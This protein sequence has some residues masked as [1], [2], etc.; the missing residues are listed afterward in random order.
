MESNKIIS[1]HHGDL[2]FS[3]KTCGWKENPDG[4]LVLCLH[5]FPDN[6]S[7][8]RHQLPALAEAGYRAISPNMRGFEPGSQASDGDYSLLALAGDVLAWLDELGEDRV[9]LVG[10]DWGAA[11]AYVAGAL[12]PE[13]FYSLTTMAVPPAS[14]FSEGVKAIPGQL[15]K[16][17]YMMFFQL[18][19][20]AEW[21]LQRN[22]WAL[23]RKLLKDWSPGYQLDEADWASL[24]NT[25]EQAGVKQAMLAYY[26]QNA[27]PKALMGAG[28]SETPD[29]SRISV[30]TMAITGDEDGCIDTRMFDHCFFEQDFPKG[31]RVERIAGA[32]HFVHLEAPDRLNALLLDWL[33]ETG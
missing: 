15:R 16:S 8:F 28:Q 25:F 9:H 17:W 14:R 22:D 24:R 29:L 5:G 1:L 23:V 6:A 13:R 32:G 7:S 31:Y 2:A 21:A 4:P 3:A 10:H 18:P 11:I 20:L 33:T 30:P 19:G 27:S 26:R 12:A